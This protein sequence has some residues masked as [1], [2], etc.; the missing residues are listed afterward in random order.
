MKTSLFTLVLFL[1]LLFGVKN[2]VNAQT[3]DDSLNS[4]E[5]V[6]IEPNPEYLKYLKGFYI[7]KDERQYDSNPDFFIPTLVMLKERYKCSL[8]YM[9]SYVVDG[10]NDPIFEVTVLNEKSYG[11]LF[12][13]L[14]Q[15]EQLYQK[16]ILTEQVI[17]YCKYTDI[18]VDRM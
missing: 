16:G 2:S 8:Y 1:V 10:V 7:P 14:S 12:L 6:K 5:I 9:E 4:L 3:I 15:L 18:I 11:A 17:L 13:S